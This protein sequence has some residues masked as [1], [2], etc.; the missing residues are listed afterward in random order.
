MAPETTPV[1]ASEFGDRERSTPKF[2]DRALAPQV[3]FDRHPMIF[4]AFSCRPRPL[5][6][7]KPRPFA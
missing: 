3:H 6:P 2:G 4:H 7:G 1:A 5:T